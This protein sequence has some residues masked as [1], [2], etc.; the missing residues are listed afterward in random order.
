M[1][2][3]T[4]PPTLEAVLRLSIGSLRRHSGMSQDDLAD[5]MADRG[6]AW[7]RATV[8][9][10]ETGR[11]SV[12]AVELVVLAAALDV[13]VSELVNPR[14]PMV[15][16]GQAVWPEPYLA[17]AVAGQAAKLVA[18][19]PAFSFSSPRVDRARADRDAS[20]VAHGDDWSAFVGRWQLEGSTAGDVAALTVDPDESEEPTP[21]PFVPTDDSNRSGAER[22]E[23]LRRLAEIEDEVALRLR[24]RTGF[25][26]QAKDVAAGSIRLWGHR[27]VREREERA[28]TAVAEGKN[29][30]ASR[31]HASRAM[32][33]E[34]SEA[35]SE[36]FDRQ[37]VKP[38]KR[39]QTRRKSR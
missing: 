24:R 22:A 31:G 12:T 39:V 16:V 8:A 33:H 9:Q 28:A 32:E 23:R 26:V 5:R 27:F 11:R 7:T 21:W 13:S 36:A 34:L 2:E 10:V 4:N 29:L 19:Y 25:P 14:T 30:Q 37:E 1:A 35:V 38:A 17:A 15:Q 3:A 18:E 6:V 20:A